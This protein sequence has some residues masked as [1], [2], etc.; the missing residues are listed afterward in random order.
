M[1]NNKYK[2]V[3]VY[4][5]YGENSLNGKVQTIETLSLKDAANLVS[6]KTILS[7]YKE[8]ISDGEEEGDIVESYI[9][10]F[11]GDICI[12]GEDHASIGHGEEE[13]ILVLAPTSPFYNIVEIDQEEWVDVVNDEWI[14][15]FES[16]DNDYCS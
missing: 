13:I 6:K 12:H 2:Y 14:K 7:F 10:D 9:E 3:P 8:G 15:L 1:K 5:S 11:V 16:F 4:T